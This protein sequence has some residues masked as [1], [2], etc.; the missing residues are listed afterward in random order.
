MGTV[1]VTG[2]AVTGTSTLW[3]AARFAV[4]ARIGFG[5]T[6]PT[7][8]TTWFNITAIASDT[9]ITLDVSAGTIA[10]GAAFVIAELRAIIV[11]T[12]AT[13]TNGG[14]FIVKGLNRDI[15]TLGGTTIP[16][17]GTVDNIRACYW[18]KDAAVQTNLAGAGS[19]RLDKISNTDHG[20][21]VLDTTNRVFVYN[22]RAALTLTAGATSALDGA[23]GGFRFATGV[24]AIVGTMSQ[25]NNGRISALA[26]GPGSGVNSL[27][28]VTTSRI[29]RCAITAITAAST[30]WQS[31]V[32]TEVPPGNSNTINATA[33]ISGIE[34]AD[35]IDRLLVMTASA[36]RHYVTQ[37]NTIGSPMDGVFLSDHRTIQQGLAALSLIAV[38]PNTLSQTPS[39]W[40]ENGLCSICLN[41]TTVSTNLIYWVAIGAHWSFAASTNQRLISPKIPTVGATKL[42]RVMTIIDNLFGSNELGLA[43]EP[44]RVYARTSGIDDNL[45]A[46]VL[47]G[48]SADLS[49]L[50]ATGLVQFMFEFKIFGSVMIPARLLGLNVTFETSDFPP[51]VVAYINDTDENNSIV[52]FIQEAVFSPSVPNFNISFYQ[53]SDNAIL[54]S[55]DST[56]TSNGVFEFWNGTVWVAGLGTNTIG[57]RRRYRATVGLPA[58]TRMYPVLRTI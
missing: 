48:K 42:Y 28:F 43:A 38:H 29:Y 21:Y 44:T 31:D 24:Q 8:I 4:G 15:F 3:Q 7:L 33:V 23:G 40:S 11:T 55:Q 20:L 12:N 51:E 52:G 39:V 53:A 2:T 30:T 19:S 9:S 46:W 57:T 41:G 37:Y 32:M 22:L 35:S 56:N 6:D 10:A 54:Q 18:I 25:N 26:H 14:L 27:Y 1:A 50:A 36:N 47:L 16:A 17:A 49:G 5:S 13:T 58:S 45:G 34:I